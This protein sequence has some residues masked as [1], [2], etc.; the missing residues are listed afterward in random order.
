MSNP[1]KTVKP[2]FKAV[3]SVQCANPNGMTLVFV[4]TC[5]IVIA[6]TEC[7]VAVFSV[8]NYL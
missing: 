2:W 7:V 6:D 5:D 1:Y 3:K 4:Q 8:I